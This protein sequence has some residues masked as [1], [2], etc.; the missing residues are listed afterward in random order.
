MDPRRL[1]TSRVLSALRTEGSSMTTQE[2]EKDK[3]LDRPVSFRLPP[4]D[5]AKLIKVAAAQGLTAGQLA[6][7]IV[8]RD[9]DIEAR[10]NHVRRA[11]AN[12]DLLRQLLGQLGRVGNNLNQIAS[13]LNGGGDRSQAGTDL[14]RL[15]PALEKALDAVL[16][17]LKRG[18]S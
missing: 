2:E 11:I 6:R 17:A 7:K 15:S 3:N 8:A 16:S 14:S 5:K 1:G 12:A 4:G 18:R 10:L 13:N 9:L